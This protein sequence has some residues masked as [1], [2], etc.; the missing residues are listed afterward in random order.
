MK[1]NTVPIVFHA[2]SYGTYLEW[3]LHTLTNDIPIIEPFTNRGGN[4]H[5]YQGHHL[6][7]M[8][9]WRKFLNSND[10]WK[11]VRLHPKTTEDEHLYDSLLEISTNVKKF[12]YIQYCSSD[13][14]L[15]LAN[16]F[17]KS[18]KN[19]WSTNLP[20][21]VEQNLYK[22]WDINP[23]VPINDIPV[24]VKRELLSYF[25]M[26]MWLSQIEW[27]HVQI[28]Q[29]A[30][31]H[32]FTVTQLLD[33]FEETINNIRDNCNLKF[34]RKVDELLPIHHKMLSLQNNRN[35]D[36]VCKTIVECV[37]SKSTYSW[38]PM[39]IVG[40]SWIQWKLRELGYEI[41]CHGLDNFPTTSVKLQ[42]LIYKA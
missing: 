15:G 36:I 41:E 11:F 17:E 12:I 27:G 6:L 2:G 22:Q 20:K 10:D 30:N 29:L 8:N 26:P 9:G 25:L 40:E 33:S 18:S 13:L 37:L 4:S 32:T 31:C 23:T 3:V 38:G 16:Q 35:I 5:G 28:H 7:D 39:S 34:V 19:W 24:W 42:E 1:N 21:S 14:L